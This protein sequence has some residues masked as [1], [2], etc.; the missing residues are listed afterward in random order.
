MPLPSYSV[1][2]KL[3]PQPARKALQY[4]A[5]LKSM[6]FLS[7]AAV[8]FFEAKVSKKNSNKKQIIKKREPCIS[9]SYLRGSDYF[10][11]SAVEKN[12]Q[13]SG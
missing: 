2:T 5:Q 10:E 13:Y 7:G 6:N 1:E 4:W 8:F 12:A 9:G 3:P 11:R